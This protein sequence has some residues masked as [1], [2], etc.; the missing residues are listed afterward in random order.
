MSITELTE[1]L[2]LTR[3]PRADAAPIEPQQ[4]S[5]PSQQAQESK[6]ATDPALES[7]SHGERKA[8][9]RICHAQIDRELDATVAA[10][11][12]QIT[13]AEGEAATARAAVTAAEREATRQ[14]ALKLV[15]EALDAFGPIVRRW[16]ENPQRPIAAELGA[17]FAE[18]AARETRECPVSAGNERVTKAL[19]RTFAEVASETAPNIITR[20]MGDAMDARFLSALYRVAGAKR[21]PSEMFAALTELEA[22]VDRLARAAGGLAV[23]DHVSKRWEIMRSQDRRE[24]AAFDTERER[25]RLANIAATYRPPTIKTKTGWQARAQ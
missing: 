2:G 22:A 12:S 16:R 10:L 14:L 21:V 5:Q 7:R 18:F 17:K 25:A 9:L 23:E 24:L 6:P 3:A 19:G 11:R 13:A 8:A 4:Q 1:R 20:F 15:S